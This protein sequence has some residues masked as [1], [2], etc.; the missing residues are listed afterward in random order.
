MSAEADVTHVTDA[1][2]VDQVLTD[3]MEQLKRS[4]GN[5]AA[6]RFGTDKIYR[7]A[8]QHAVD[9]VLAARKNRRR[10]AVIEELA[11]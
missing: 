7:L 2:E 6:R 3:I 4:A 9:I 11:P 5:Y 8:M 10:V 1:G